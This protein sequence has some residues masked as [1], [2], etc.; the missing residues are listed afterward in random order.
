MSRGHERDLIAWDAIVLQGR[1]SDDFA[2]VDVIE[3]DEV[4][5]YEK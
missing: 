4:R 3:I 5:E 2:V 1:V